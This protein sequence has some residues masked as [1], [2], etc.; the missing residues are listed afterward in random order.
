LKPKPGY[1]LQKRTRV[2]PTLLFLDKLAFR[3][4]LG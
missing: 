4:L 1:I 3:T 2:L